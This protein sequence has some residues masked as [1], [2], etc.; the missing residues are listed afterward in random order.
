MSFIYVIYAINKYVFTFFPPYIPSLLYRKSQ[1][2][3]EFSNRKPVI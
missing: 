1:L 2:K 3:L